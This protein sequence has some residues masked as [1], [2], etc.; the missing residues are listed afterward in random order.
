MVIGLLLKKRC[1]TLALSF[2]VVR[3]S[4]ARYPHLGCGPAIEIRPIAMTDK[5]TGFTT[6]GSAVSL[7]SSKCCLASYFTSASS[8]SF[9]FDEE[10]GAKIEELKM[11][12]GVHNTARRIRIHA[13]RT[14]S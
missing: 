9:L 12:E 13:F 10:I 4:Q 3:N 8:E 5:S 11:I 2:E 14:H 6:D 1:C 7:V